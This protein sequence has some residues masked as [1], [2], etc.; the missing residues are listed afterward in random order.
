MSPKSIAILVALGTAGAVGVA[1]AITSLSFDGF[2]EGNAYLA[3]AD[4]DGAFAE[5][6]AAFI[7]H[8]E[9]NPVIS[10]ADRE[11]FRQVALRRLDFVSQ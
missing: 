9:V 6:E 2:A 4:F 7:Q 10:A 11:G 1:P 5:I 8:Q 3:R